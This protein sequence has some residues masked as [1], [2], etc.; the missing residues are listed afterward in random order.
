[1]NEYPEMAEFG[2]RMLALGEVAEAV[3]QKAI[4]DVGLFVDAWAKRIGAS[5]LPPLPKPK[6]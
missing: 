6:L 3:G 1:M 4:H 2:R 5:T